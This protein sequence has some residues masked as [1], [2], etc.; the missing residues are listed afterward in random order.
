[1]HVYKNSFLII[2]VCCLLIFSV[3]FAGPALGRK[4]LF[5]VDS[6]PES[7]SKDCRKG[8]ARIYDECGDQVAIFNAALERA[9]ATGKTVL[10]VYGAEWCIWCHVFDKY[11]KGGHSAFAYRWEY[12]GERN[13]VD[14]FERENPQAEAQAKSLNRY[15]S[16]N[17][18]LAHIESD[19]APNGPEVLVQVGYDPASIRYA[20]FIFVVTGEG[21]YVTYLPNSDELS[22]LEIRED[23]GEQYRGYNRDVLLAELKRLRNMSK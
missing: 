19:Y 17:F 14:F 23:S 18:V 10:V 5:F 1:M 20:P 9:N 21:Q 15:V 12:Q 3:G 7:V 8:V 4:S 2:S 16:E 6:F 13:A 11:V 22:N